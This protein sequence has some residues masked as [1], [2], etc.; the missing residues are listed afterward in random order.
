MSK[1][2]LPVYFP[3]NEPYLGR[4]V[5]LAFDKSIPPSLE[6]HARIAVRTFQGGLSELQVAA[7]EIIPQGVSIALSIR[8]LVRQAYLYSAGILLRP[9]VERAGTI[10]Y[11]QS[12]PD[13][14]QLWK[15]GWPRK[16]QP[17]LQDLLDL[18][19]PE[20]QCSDHSIVRELMNK[21]VHSDPTGSTF[22]MVRR[23][24]GALAFSS[25]KIIDDPHFCDTVCAAGMCYLQR[26]TATAHE[27][28]PDA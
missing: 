7:T 8:D 22:N 13:A 20:W 5:L 14:V 26:L 18:L 19:H 10:R 2:P 11:L 25:G 16:M 24:D 28:F 9:L 1:E 15:S 17:T 21:L 23:S 3:H 4:Q 12:K 6:T 27:I